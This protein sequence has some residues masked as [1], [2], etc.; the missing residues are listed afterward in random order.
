MRRL[1]LVGPKVGPVFDPIFGPLRQRVGIWLLNRTMRNGID[2]RKLRFLPDS[3]TLPLK[4]DGLDPLPALMDVQ[5]EAPVKKLADMFGKTVWLVS[6]YDEAKEVLA[7]DAASW[8]N[9]LGQFV[10]QEGRSDEEQIGGL[11]MIDP[12]LHTELR[13]YLTPEFTMRRLARL[14]PGIEEI[15]SQRLDAMAAAGA[16]GQAVD[17]VQE[18]AFAVPFDVICDLL[19]LPVD[20]R[21]RF[22]ELGVA[23]FDLT[24]GGAGAFGAAAHTREFLINAVREQ[25]KNPGD[26]LIGALLKE[27]G[28]TLDDVTLGGIADGVFLG[29]YETSASMLA[30]GTY[31]IAT[32]PEAGRMLRSDPESVDRVVEELLRHLC[33]VQLAFLRFAKA[34][35]VVGGVKIKAGDAVGVSLLAANRDPKLGDDLGD[36]DPTREPTRHLAFGWGMHRCVGAEL[37]RM[38]L[39]TS[40]RMLAERFPDLTMAADISALEFRKLSAVYG[41]EALPVHLAGPVRETATV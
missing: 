21:A 18:F 1:P 15:V 25:R 12:P 22:L 36:F 10:S 17:M 9:D 41:V 30:L 27:H 29:G 39:R 13:R 33:V 26:G 35:V 32:T 11:G 3:V 38:E 34:D 40:L 8:S 20:D 28:D 24:E 5:A 4:R 6:G 2:L 7:G 23:R 19:G 37:A 16:D 14:Q 31:L